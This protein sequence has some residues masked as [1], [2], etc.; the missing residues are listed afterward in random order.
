MKAVIMA[1][2]EGTRL[3]PLTANQPKPMLPL[4]NRPI[5]EHI[6]THVRNHGVKDIV[7]TVQFLASQVRNYFGDGTD[8]GV[9]LAYAT[10]PTPLGTAGSVRNAA[11]MLD[12]TFVVIS[13]DALTDIDLDEVLG[14]HRRRGALATVALK[15]MPNPLEFG[16]VITTDDGRIERFLEKPHWGQVFSDTINTGIYVLEPEVFE[17][18]P[19]GPADFAA[20]VFPRL[21]AQGAPLFGFV[22]DG[23]WED[24]GTLEAYQRAHQDIL[25]G[26][27]QVD[28]R[29][30]Q[31]RP[32][33]WIGEG[34][35]L[36][37]DAKL[38]APVLIGDF[39]K[40]EAGVRLREYTVVGSGVVV[41][42][43]AF[44]HRAIVH[45]NAYIGPGANLRGC[46]VGRS[47]DIK[48]GGRIE[49]GVVVGDNC[50][51]GPDAIIQ[52]NVKI[53][54]YKTV[55]PGATVT[56]SIIW[57]GR[58]AR[59]LF[60]EY[61]ITGIANIDLTPELALRVA[62]AFGST[63]KKG[64]RVT[65]GRDASRISRALKRAIIAGMNSAGVTCED[66]EL[67]PA[68]SVRFSAAR[69]GASGGIYV[70]TSP[71][72]SQ[73]IEL[74]VFGDD[75]S[76]LDEGA[77]RRIERTYYR[78]EFRR[79]FGQEMGE[80]RYPPRAIEHYAVSLVHSLDVAAVRHRRFKVVIDA[81]G[82]TATLVLPHLLSRLGL[83]TLIVNG[84]LD[85][86]RVAPTDAEHQGDL[87]RLAK[88]V[89]ASG[90]DLGVR[91]DAVGERLTLVDESGTVV[92]WDRALLLYVDLVVRSE[93]AGGIALPIST[94][95][96][97]AALAARN[98]CQVHGTKLAASA[99]MRAAQRD[100]V[101]FAGAEGG[102]YV[103]PVMHPAYDGLLSF[104][105]LLE[106]LAA[107]ET[108]LAEA[109]AALP[110]PC[111]VRRR[112]PTPWER[113]G[114]VMRQ[115]MEAAKGRRVEDTDGVKVFH[116][117]AAGEAA[118]QGPDD[119]ALIIPDTVDPVTHLWAEAGSQ[120]DARA[121]AERYEAL[122][123]RVAEGG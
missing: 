102:G 55:E 88:L 13:G 67:A 10:E 46:V 66:L 113:K 50:D 14:F 74:A 63:L 40:V 34:A 65:L 101:V 112:V 111:L 117:P 16:I 57:E 5:M 54:P 36:D 73:S 115:V 24:V 32:G 72:D 39:T 7:V 123:R 51:I 1:G 9:D 107:H 80:L 77:R 27:V 29:G 49:D 99:I 120:A 52:P 83:D 104:G 41:K 42:R 18:I 87:D 25:D 84:Q 22:A 100:G 35:E 17:H 64:S 68:P 114:A 19:D 47:A 53:Y 85:E 79:A 37:P 119:W 38:T 86:T 15:R 31:V 92:G 89:T 103:F 121:L 81:G 118:G 58:G 71:R 43:D 45:D 97:A 11:E 110:E 109:V 78:E 59:S 122:I 70:R 90:A 91:F 44:L 93:P 106:L 69:L 3:R 20:D 12:D 61:G 94:T 26:R 23:Y 48:R 82:G 4:G 96:L 98:G 33:V 105:K 75:G 56:K 76:D 21:L 108:G 62:M 116:P 28:V 60:D 95:R 2:G 6:V 8:M 30:F